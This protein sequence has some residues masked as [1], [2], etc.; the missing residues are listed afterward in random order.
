MSHTSKAL[1]AGLLTYFLVH[2]GYLVSG[3]HPIRNLPGALGWALDVGVW[4][5]VYLVVHGSLGRLTRPAGR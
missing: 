4:A 1:L 5:C 2:A 3:F